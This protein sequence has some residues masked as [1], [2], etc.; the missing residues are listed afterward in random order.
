MQNKLP[1]PRSGFTL[2]EVLIA[3][4]VLSLALLALMRTAAGQAETFTAVRERILADWLA[5]VVIA[6]TRIGNPL[7]S[8][9]RNSGQRRF[10]GRDWRWELDVQPTQAATIRRLDVRISTALAPTVPVVTLTGF[11]GI[12][13][14]H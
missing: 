13:L 11:T 7:P 4:F 2:L 12:D 6:E 1:P 5:Q 3:L 10:G 8:P 14:Q 9:G